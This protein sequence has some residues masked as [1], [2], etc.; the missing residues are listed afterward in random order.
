MRS[1]C[2]IALNLTSEAPFLTTVTVNASAPIAIKDAT[3]NYA[4]TAMLPWMSMANALVE[5]GLYI[6]GWPFN[7]KFPVETKKGGGRS[8]GMKDLKSESL[9]S[10]LTAFESGSIKLR[11]GNK[12]GK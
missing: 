6:E 8:Q 10:M 3:G 12:D 4:R 11:A 7:V 5:R 9:K 1:V 2:Y